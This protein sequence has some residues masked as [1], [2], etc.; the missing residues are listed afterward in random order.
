VVTRFDLYAPGLEQAGLP[1]GR[2]LFGEVR[3]D[4]GPE[5]TRPGGGM[6][7]AFEPAG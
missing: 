1:P 7:C 6:S 3:D 5:S 4:F 2:L